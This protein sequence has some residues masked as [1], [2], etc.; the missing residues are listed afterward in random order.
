LFPLKTVIRMG[1]DTIKNILNDFGLTEKESE[2]YIFL[3]KHGVLKCGEIAKG[4]KRHKA[5][6]YRILKI[7]ECKGLLESTLETPTRFTPVPFE[8][9]LDL[10]IKA[11]YDEAVLMEKNRKEVVNY[12]KNLRQTA[13]ETSL[14]KFLVLEGNQKIYQ[15]IAQLIKDAKSNLSIV[16]DIPG[17]LRADNFGVF[18]TSLSYPT[19]SK[20]QFH[21]LTEILEPNLP[22]VK[23]LLEN[24]R[25]S[26][27]NFKVKNPDLGIQL[28]P[29]MVIKD[30]DEMLFFI[31][32]KAN[33]AAN[34]E[35]LCLWTN[36]K[37]LVKSFSGVFEDLWH[38]SSDIHIKLTEIET[39]KP[40]PQ[41]YTISNPQVYTKKFDEILEKSKDDVIIITSAD[42]LVHL[43]RKILLLK[44]WAGNGVFVRIMAPIVNENLQAAKVLSECCFVK[45][46]PAV[47]LNTTLVDGQYLIQSK[48]QLASQRQE[49]TLEFQEAF[50]TTDTAYVEKTKNMLNDL[51][52]NCRELS[53]VTI[54]SL[55]E[56]LSPAP[57]TLPRKNSDYTKMMGWI[58]YP[59]HG[60]ISETE[61]LNRF[62]EGKKLLAKNPSKDIARFY[63]SRGIGIIHPPENFHLPDIII[64]IL[65][66]NEKSS[67]GAEN[68]LMFLSR[69]NTP[70]GHIFLPVA[71]VGDNP[72]A[73][74]F[75]KGTQAGTPSAKTQTVKQDELQIRLEGNTLFA[76]WTIP[77]P[78]NS[79]SYVLPPAC[80]LL[81]A[82]GGTKTAYRKSI[83][84]SG[85]MQIAE[86][87][88]SEASLTFFHPA[89]K[90]SGLGTEAFLHK[91][92]VSTTYPPGYG[93]NEKTGANG[94][95]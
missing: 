60:V 64:M 21:F 11:K 55:K 85:R 86:F 53:E 31:T 73:M 12:W 22:T 43:S 28:P 13:L 26:G 19:Q 39:G 52:K 27:F 37:E 50:Y 36:C 61:I 35:E 88:L 32:K 94:A 14:Q 76:G 44:K 33:Q 49:E 95:K 16:M 78:L 18:D 70:N 81:E 1:E 79:S 23:A 10:S 62:H 30:N 72:D 20:V 34:A 51:W 5:Q 41:S 84:P 67:F 17:L 75:L 83:S 48:N 58:D 40:T 87:T 66:F 57:P 2:V 7:L 25:N 69:V 56:F 15:K 6:I 74:E 90:Y 71:T 24:N 45:H 3:S 59:K 65:L 80:I 4:M 77:I 82:F 8:K 93:E 63:G 42:E 68:R 29:R 91:Y 92:C 89:S 46:I 47:Y 9:A 38:H 54:V